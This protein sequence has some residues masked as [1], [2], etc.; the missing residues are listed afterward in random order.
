VKRGRR[1]YRDQKEKDKKEARNARLQFRQIL[2]LVPAARGGRCG[3]GC[4]LRIAPDIIKA[5]HYTAM[6]GI[7]SC[8][9][10]YRERPVR[11][12]SS[13]PIPPESRFVPDQVQAMCE[14]ANE[15]QV[16]KQSFSGIPDPS[17]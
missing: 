12:R 16:L 2:K 14:R 1:L 5:L 6:K 10:T 8:A 7:Y 13:Q 3:D 11:I 15:Y 9:G 17:A 4:A